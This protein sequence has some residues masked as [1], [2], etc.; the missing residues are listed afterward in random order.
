M[1]TRPSPIRARIALSSL[2][3]LFPAAAVLADAGTVQQQFERAYF[4]ETHDGDAQAAAELYETVAKDRSAPPALI[5]EARNRAARCREDS[6]SQDLAVLMPQDTI[7]Y[8]EVRRPGQH[9]AN[10]AGLLGLVGD[11]LANVRAGREAGIPIPDAPGLAIPAEIFLSPAILREADRFRGAA[12]A[13]TGIQ[14]PPAGVAELGGVQALLVL[15]PG[16]AAGLRG[17]LETGAQFVQ[18]AEPIGG[19]GTVRIEPGIIVTFTH[20]LVIAGTSRELVAGA[21]ERLASGKGACLADRAD[22]QALAERRATALFFAFVD[23]KRG[24]ATVHQQV[25]HEPDAAQAL[26]VAQGL[27]D[28]GHWQSACV[29]LG[30]SPEGLHG[31][32]VLSLDEGHANVIYN[33]IRTPPMS[34]RALRAVP[35]GSAAVVGIGINPPRAGQDA[36]AAA[37]PAS[38]TNKVQT[39]RYVTGLDLGRELFAN[40]EEIVAFVLPG[41]RREG[42]PIPDA[43]LII[44]SADPA[45]SQMLWDQLLGLPALVQGQDHPQPTSR[46]IAGHQA[47]AYTLPNG[48]ELLVAQLDHSIVIAPTE[49]AI[50]AV[51]ETLGNGQSILADAGIKA[52]VEQI[53]PDTSILLMAHAGRCAQV[54]AQFCPEHEVEEVQTVGRMLGSMLVTLVADESPTR[55]RVA[56]SIRGLPQVKDMIRLAA[57]HLTERQ[58]REAQV[59]VIAVERSAETVPSGR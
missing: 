57:K 49:R 18:P 46:T 1:S 29:T 19:F 8:V 11:P 55:L 15:H 5:D 30:S 20:R 38:I 24:F 3:L 33:L 4:L 42:P 2:P 17:A 14:P 21:V 47:R 9:L 43:G 16:D 31:E 10:L 27:L 48:M 52:A 12:F 50:A 56:G 35:A 53:T 13:F 26:G 54:A 36:A 58:P 51:V 28:V 44:A 23:A 7:A 34:G 45:K 39:V 59:S 37:D 40:I 25:G 32:L 6:R 41:E 22:V